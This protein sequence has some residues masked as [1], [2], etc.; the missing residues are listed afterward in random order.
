MFNHIKTRLIFIIA[1]FL[2]NSY[3]FSQSSENS[4]TGTIVDQAT[5]APME[6]V[7]VVV[8]KTSDS[9]Q[10]AGTTTDKNGNFQFDNLNRGEYYL[11]I[12][13]IGFETL[14]TRSVKIANSKIDL[15]KLEIK[16]NPI[17]LGDV[18][19]T[20]EKGMFVNSIDRKIYNVEKD[21]ITQTGSASELLQNIPS[22]SVDIDGNVSLR[23]ASNV[24]IFIDGKPSLLMRKNSA[25]VLQ[26]LPANSIERVEVI[27]NP[28]A[29]YK[30]DGI[31][32]IIN[33]VL[34]KTS[35]Y[36][37]NGTVINN[38]GNSGRYNGNLTLNYNPG[39]MNLFG[40]YGF[41]RNNSPRINT[42]YRIQR[43]S[44]TL[45]PSYYDNYSSATSKPTAHVL[46]MGLDYSPDD[47]N[48]FGVSGNYF[49]ED[50]YRIQNS[51]TTFRDALREI[52][53]DF[54][55]E[56]ILDETEI[57][58]E[59]NSS[60][61]HHFKKE[62]HTIQFELNYSGY[63]ETEDNRYDEVYTVPANSE[64]LHHIK[65]QKGGHQTEFYAE[66]AYPFSEETTLEAGYVGEFVYDDIRY[67]GEDFNAPQQRWITDYNKTNQFLFHQNIHAFYAT[68]GHSI[69][70]FGFLAG[71]RAEQ[72]LITSKLVSADS[73]IPNNYFSLY[74]TLHLAYNVNDENELQLNYSRRIRRADSDEHNP[75]AEYNDPRNLEAGNPK[76][77]PEQIHS[78]EFGY[79]FKKDNFS[80][81]P[82]IFYRYK[83]DAFAEVH[84]FIND[85]TMLSTFENIAHDKSAGMELILAHDIK[86]LVSLNLNADA[87][88]Q[89][90]DASN[91]GYSE[92]KSTISWNL[93]FAANFH[94]T[95]SNLIQINSYYR[96]A[97][98]SP[99]GKTNPLMLMNFGMRQELF[100]QRAAL[101]L[102]VSD[103]FNSLKRTRKIDTPE[104]YSEATRKRNSQIVF[105]G[106]TW[107]FGKSMKKSDK[108]E[109]N[110]E[111][112][113]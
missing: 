4:L 17:A 56:R 19:V 26:Q 9:S 38:V 15:G 86:K 112:K 3:T 37:F 75:F 49:Y 76:I 63:D 7:N 21:I 54:S 103:V 89:V 58:Y 11:K 98:L 68:L 74:P 97:R 31:G 10:V 34:K 61:E 39:N 107:H 69:E 73:T 24:T 60:Y 99:E 108:Q 40:S 110:F 92:N 100:H 22:V 88:Y 78:I 94:L 62:D 35:R 27:T 104:L 95:Q 32:G 55:T 64:A 90:I 79:H 93:K 52:T 67:L 77:K 113:I 83:Y 33:L 57:E 51:Q 109:L 1:L 14:K 46:N 66:Y 105:L 72:T 18:E 53:S 41:R 44:L 42:D 43:D 85:S 59:I 30:P 36:G 87:F 12:T 16:I 6:L 47:N 8:F 80:I 65:I 91:L 48:Q 102:T 101:T 82:N 28:S 70:D 111:D 45:T 50:T 84:H 20:A 25:V 13:F 96:S 81:L 5:K 2:M 106:F 23:G 29:K 71:L